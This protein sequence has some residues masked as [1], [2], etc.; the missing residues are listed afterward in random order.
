MRNFISPVRTLILFIFYLNSDF[1]F[2]QHEADNWFFGRRVGLSFKNGIPEPVYGSPI[3]QVEGTAVATDAKSGKLLFYTNGITVWNF[4]HEIM[5]NGEGLLGSGTSTQSALVLPFPGRSNLYYLFTTRSF[6]DRSGGLHYSIVDMNSSNGEGAIMTDKKNILL[7]RLGSEK[8]TAIPHRNRRDFWL[9]SH[10]WDSDIFL[11]YLVSPLGLSEA[12]EIKIGTVHRKGTIEINIGIGEEMGTLK[13]SPDG[14]M[15]AAAVYG[16]NRPFELYDFNNALGVI[17]NFRSLGNFT[18]QYS[19]S[20]S[21]DNSKLYLAAL[22]DEGSFQF[23]LND[24]T[25]GPYLIPLANST[26]DSTYV[27]GTMQLG[28]DGKLY[29]ASIDK[30]G[31]LVINSPNSSREAIDIEELHFDLKGGRILE[32]LPNFLQSTFNTSP[33]SPYLPD[34][35]DCG[36][37]LNIFPNP[38]IADEFTIQ[39]DSAAWRSSC[40]L[41]K[42]TVYLQSGAQFF[43]IDKAINDAFQVNVKHWPA[44]VYLLE[45]EYRHR[46]IVKKLVRM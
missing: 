2:A 32:G 10:R 36:Q 8:L 34:I 16:E 43:S 33:V 9:I 29:I 21:P 19:L 23:N 45:F 11:I 37:D 38:V 17:S 13:G 14:S 31:L 28:P 15:L 5:S 4:R 26:G 42:F 12:N 20:F 40:E 22:S 3:N 27:S 39:M 46:R 30:A 35:V 18:S 25:S 6:A 7:E 44:G 24:L 41:L 1:L